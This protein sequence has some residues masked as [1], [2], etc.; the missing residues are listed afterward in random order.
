MLGGMSDLARA[1]RERGLRA[2][3]QSPGQRG[4]STLVTC[5][6]PSGIEEAR[7]PIAAETLA[8]GVVVSGSGGLRWCGGW[9]RRQAVSLGE[10]RGVCN[11]ILT[12][13]GSREVGSLAGSLEAY[14]GSSRNG[15]GEPRGT[16][17]NGHLTQLL[18]CD[19]RPQSSSL[20][21][22]KGEINLFKAA[23]PVRTHGR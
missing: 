11:V 21:A 2:W 8:G 18:P 7:A 20:G 10:A 17:S 19:R 14:G 5:R 12:W 1:H 13:M 6:P 4:L 15:A 16:N 22:V 3:S 23:R 9:M